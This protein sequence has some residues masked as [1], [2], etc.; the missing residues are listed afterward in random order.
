MNSLWIIDKRISIN[1]IRRNHS[2]CDWFPKPQTNALDQNESQLST[3]NMDFNS[4]LQVRHKL[5]S[6]RERS[7]RTKDI[8]TLSHMP[9]PAVDGRVRQSNNHRHWHLYWTKCIEMTHSPK[10]YT[11]TSSGWPQFDAVSISLAT[12]LLV[13]CAIWRYEACAWG[14]ADTV[15]PIF[16]PNLSSKQLYSGVTNFLFGYACAIGKWPDDRSQLCVLQ[17]AVNNCSDKRWK[18]KCN[19]EQIFLVR[20]VIC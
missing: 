16:S 1:F 5:V 9:T 20:P 17:R 18:L 2:R 19:D 14:N 8:Y 4:K 6:W 15:A 12:D 7:I 3:P 10:F 11:S 13:E